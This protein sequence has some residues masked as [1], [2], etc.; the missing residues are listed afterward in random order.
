MLPSLRTQCVFFAL[1]LVGCVPGNSSPDYATNSKKFDLGPVT[2]RIPVGWKAI[3]Y[4][5][6]G[7]EHT[8]K[9][10]QYHRYLFLNV[11]SSDTTLRETITLTV[12]TRQGAPQAR[13][14]SRELAKNLRAFPDQLQVLTF[15]DTLLHHGELAIAEA[16]C[17]NLA[18]HVDF[19]QLYAFSTKKNV[20]VAFM[21]TARNHAGPTNEQNRAVFRQAIQSITWK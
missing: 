8:D 11:A 19:L 18:E 2:I 1:L 6:S 17:R 13:K 3:E 14:A 21:G 5:S 20:L 15:Q 4:D 10:P 16:T 12:D 9:G 7:L